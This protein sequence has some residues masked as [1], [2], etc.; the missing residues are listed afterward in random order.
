M[1]LILPEAVEDLAD[2]C[3]WY[4]RKLPE[5]ELRFQSD[6]DGSLERILKE[7]AVYAADEDGLPRVRMAKFPYH[8]GYLLDD[9]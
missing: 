5:L 4:R 6:F 1:P 3:K 2:I 8:I 7:P 9:D